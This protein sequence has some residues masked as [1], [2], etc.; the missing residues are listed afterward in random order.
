LV[1]EIEL[2]ILRQKKIQRK[3]NQIL[4]KGRNWFSFQ[5][6][7]KKKKFQQHLED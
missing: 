5:T 4:K 1:G 3:Q 2:R 6:G 7:S